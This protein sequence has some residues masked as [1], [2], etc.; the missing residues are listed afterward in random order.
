MQLKVRS[1]GSGPRTALLV[2]GFSDDSETWWRVSPAIADLGFTVLAPDLRGHGKS[3]RCSSYALPEIAQDL[4]DSL[5]AE[6]DVALG[7]SLGAVVLGLAAERL[8][9]RRAVFVDPS[10]LRPRGEVS[11]TAAL[12]L[13]PSDL[14][15]ELGWS[16]A[17]VA[18][19]L[20]SNR[21]TDPLV[22]TSLLA[23]L[24]PHEHIE[25]PPAP[26]PGALVLVPEL[27]PVLPVA[28]HPV[29]AALGYE[30][31]TLAGVRHVL[32]RDDFD[33]FMDLLRPDLLDGGIAA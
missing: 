18:V 9:P 28:A 22:A 24:A 30:I 33:G 26:H 21:R 19:D 7:H 8:R 12:P 11:L 32:H 17:E 14:P 13:A 20:A 1:W 31:R 25:P 16:A 3:P 2:H 15:A 29:L 4:V 6:A 10:W 27:S 23:A 5:P